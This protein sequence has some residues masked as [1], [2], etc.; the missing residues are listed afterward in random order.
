MWET[1]EGVRASGHL[2]GVHKVFNQEEM[3][4]LG[5]RGDHSGCNLLGQMLLLLLSQGQVNIQVGPGEPKGAR[6]LKGWMGPRLR[7]MTGTRARNG[8]WGEGQV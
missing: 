8:G 1:Q 4:K 2:E 6:P 3:P 5:G 7:G